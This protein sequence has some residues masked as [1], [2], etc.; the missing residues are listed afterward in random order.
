MGHAPK[1]IPQ[2]YVAL[3]ILQNGLAMRDAQEWISKRVFALLGLTLGRQ[4]TPLVPDPPTRVEAIGKK[5]K[6]HLRSRSLEAGEGAAVEAGA[7]KTGCD[8]VCS[9]S[10][11]DLD[12]VVEHAELA[13]R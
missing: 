12:A 4:D 11:E 8:L 10:I 9:K 6:P 1:G 13:R 2:D 7:A 3:L 5:R